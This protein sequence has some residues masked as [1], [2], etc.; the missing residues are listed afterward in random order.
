MKTWR[1]RAHGCFETI[2]QEPAGSLDKPLRAVVA[3][4]PRRINRYIRLAL[5]GVHRCIN[6]LDQPLANDT[7]LYIASEQGSAAEAVDLMDDIVVRGRWPKP[8]SFVNVSSNMV[9]YYLA[10]GLGLNGRNMNVARTHDAFGAMLDLAR[11]EQSMHEG[12]ED[13]MLLGSVVECVWPLSDHRLRCDVPVDIPMVES[14]Y[15]LVVEPD[16]T[17]QPTAPKLTSGKAEDETTAREWLAAGERWLIDPHLPAECRSELTT[18]LDE[19]R[20]L[21]APLCH[22]GHQDAVVHALFTALQADP[23]P[24][25]TVA[26][27]DPS[28]GY[29]LLGIE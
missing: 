23:I 6:K 13:S 26:A 2:A 4:P 12:S 25:L 18:G 24:K 9:G 15:W 28:G 3:R 5:I 1:I 16:T 21:H 8:M 29:Q 17:G 11:L 19:S 7:P 20:R 14:S 22:H 10:A 27:S